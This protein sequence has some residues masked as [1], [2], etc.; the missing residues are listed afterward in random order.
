VPLSGI[1][2]ITG[3]DHACPLT[4]RA[5]YFAGRT[6]SMAASAPLAADTSD[7]LQARYQAPGYE[8][9]TGLTS[10]DACLH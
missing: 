7:S 2:Q 8:T 10:Q 3:Q 1:V 4:K 9:P 5:E 6:I